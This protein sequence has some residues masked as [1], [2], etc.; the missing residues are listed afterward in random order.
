MSA[1][2]GRRWRVEVPASPVGVL[3]RHDTAIRL[4]LGASASGVIAPL[5]AGGT[6]LAVVGAIAG[7]VA[8][9]GISPLVASL[10][11]A[12]R[13]NDP[14]TLGAV[15]LAVVGIS[16]TTAWAIARNAA[17]VDPAELLRG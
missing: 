6:L 7:T 13:P 4:A 9:L 3:Q 8:S 1:S 10:M 16:I 17:R 15:A 12:I 2:R 14:L 5:V 11:F